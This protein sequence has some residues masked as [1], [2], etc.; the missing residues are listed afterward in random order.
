MSSYVPAEASWLTD[1][2]DQDRGLVRKVLEGIIAYDI[3]QSIRIPAPAA[4]NGVLAPRP[5]IT[6]SS[7]SCAAHCRSPS[8]NGPALAATRSCVNS[9]RIRVF[10]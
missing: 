7:R 1:Q 9:G 10:I 5:W 4:D 8:K 2:A 3:A 6:A